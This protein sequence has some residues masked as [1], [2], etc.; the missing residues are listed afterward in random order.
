MLLGFAIFIFSVPFGF[1]PHV[2]A[3]P[4]NL[5]D[6]SNFFAKNKKYAYNPG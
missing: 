3:S 6:L 4:S 5:N 2:F 1:L